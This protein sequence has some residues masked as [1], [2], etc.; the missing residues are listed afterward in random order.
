MKLGLE[1]KKID[2]CVNDCDGHD[3]WSLRKKDE[4]DCDGHDDCMRTVM[5]A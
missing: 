1:S 4:E 3:N 5:S 2:C